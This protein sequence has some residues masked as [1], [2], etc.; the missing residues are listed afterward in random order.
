MTAASRLGCANFR[1]TLAL[2]RRGLLKVG[3]LGASGLT[4]S[5]LLR[6]ER[7]AAA[8]GL[9]VKKDTSVII[10][11]MRGGPSQLDMWDMKPE[12][13]AEIRGEFSP[14]STN[15]PGIQLSEL[16]PLSAERM[17]RWSIIRSMHF[18]AEDGQTDHSSGD[19][20]CFTGYPAGNPPDAN[21]YPSVLDR[22]AAVAASRSVA[23]ELRDGAAQRAWHC[24]RLSRPGLGAV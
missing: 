23:A 5:N 10:L 13:P 16:L 7:M 6:A 3:A 8:A 9:P 2:N 17:D 19:Q 21:V 12:A 1:Q 24:V 4:L 22:K 20:V 14:I 18:R 11:W 15:V